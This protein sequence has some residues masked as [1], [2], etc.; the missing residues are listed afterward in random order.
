MAT[1][2]LLRERELVAHDATSIVAISIRFDSAPMDISIL[3]VL[4]ISLLV[5]FFTITLLEPPTHTH[6]RKSECSKGW[7]FPY[8]T[9]VG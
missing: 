9:K 8:R 3:C 5:T 4:L 7:N 1:Y 2:M 6:A